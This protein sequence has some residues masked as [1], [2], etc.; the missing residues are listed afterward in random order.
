MIENN[1]LTFYVIYI[2]PILTVATFNFVAYIVV[3]YLKVIDNLEG[4]LIFLADMSLN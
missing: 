3:G 2:N 4:Y 1:L